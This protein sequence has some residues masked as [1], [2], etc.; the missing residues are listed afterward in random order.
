MTIRGV[1]KSQFKSKKIMISKKYIPSWLDRIF[2]RLFFRGRCINMT[3]HDATFGYN[4]IIFNGNGYYRGLGRN[5]YIE[6][7]IDKRL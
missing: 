3:F 7:K 6:T 2:H 5:W 4:D 1:E